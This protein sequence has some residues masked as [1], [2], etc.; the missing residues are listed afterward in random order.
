MEGAATVGLAAG[1][2]SAVAFSTTANESASMIAIKAT[3]M[4]EAAPAIPVTVMSIVSTGVEARTIES[5]IPVGVTPAVIPRS[6]ADEHA[7]N[8]PLWS[9]VPVGR[10]TVG[11]VWI[12]AIFTNW[13]SSHISWAKTDSD[14]HSNLGIGI[15]HRQQHQHSKQRQIF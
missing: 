2:E 13:R 10:T 4:I 9:V 15:R 6:S 7:A 3:F 5:V 14:A 11:I 12:I 8:K 1:Y